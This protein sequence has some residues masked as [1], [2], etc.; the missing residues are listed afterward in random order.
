[1]GYSYEKH[2][3]GTITNFWPDNTDYEVYVA[4]GISLPEIIELVNDKWPDADFDSIS[5]SSENIH[6]S[7]LTYDLL[8]PSDYTNFTVITRTG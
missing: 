5:I 2:N 7:C 4:G 8:D 1:M 6:T 3:G